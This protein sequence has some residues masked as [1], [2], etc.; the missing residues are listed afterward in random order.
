[1]TPPAFTNIEFAAVAADARDGRIKWPKALNKSMKVD[2]EYAA[3]R[4]ATLCVSE[5]GSFEGA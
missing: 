5:F 1:M 2:G 3:S 4:S